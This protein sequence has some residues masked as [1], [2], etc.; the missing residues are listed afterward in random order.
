VAH[1]LRSPLASLAGWLEMADDA[2]TDDD[3]ASATSFVRRARASGDRMLQVI[4]DWL[5]YTVQR[6]GLLAPTD[7]A[8]KPLVAAVVA[9]FASSGSALAPTFDVD[10]DDTVHADPALTRQLFAN[11]VGNA[12]KYTPAGARP[13]VT[14]RSGP[15]EEPGFVR[16]TVADR[17]IGL[18][19][20][21]EEAVFR[22]FHRA[23]GHATDYAGTGLGL[24]LCRK[25]V[26]RH[27]GT[28]RAYNDPDHGTVFSF[29]LPAA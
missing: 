14:I 7:V 24:S 19:P 17:G 3:G 18:P 23:P 2:L 5:S 27:G 29:T 4:E 8:L 10:V 13:Q 6:D 20:G 22:E 16:V 15:D 28:I 26:V 25:I 21:Q 11:L 9:P 12:V 1:D